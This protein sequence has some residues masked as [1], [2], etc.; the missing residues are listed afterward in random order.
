MVSKDSKKSKYD[1]TRTAEKLG[2]KNYKEVSFQHISGIHIE[3]FRS[4]TN[5]DIKLG[6]YLTLITGKNGTM[7]SSILGLI[8]HP[9]SS[10]N[11]AKDMYGKDLK[12]KHSDVF[13]LSL[14]N[15][16]NEYIYYLQAL[17]TTNKD[18]SEPVRLY[19]S[20]N[21]HRV[22]VGP[23]NKVAKGNFLLNTSYLNLKRLFPIIETNATQ[24]NIKISEDD[25]AKISKAYQKIMQRR[26]YESS[27]TIS[28][29]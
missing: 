21:R 7:K 9:F 28:E 19:P 23:D 3:H 4:L 6:K 12:T 15:D 27:E 11:E 14:K 24:A 22:T 13:K 29:S 8:A 17:T 2:Y 1:K 10:P 20:G 16:S 25:Q 18:L 5:R 26:A